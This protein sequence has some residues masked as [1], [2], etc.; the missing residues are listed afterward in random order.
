MANIFY[1]HPDNPQQRLIRQAV[2]IL[3]KQG[4]IVLPTD[5]GY[6]LATK[7][8]NKKGQDRMSYVVTYRE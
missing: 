3:N 4:V 7:I 8:D 6:A 5:S 1:V 2:D